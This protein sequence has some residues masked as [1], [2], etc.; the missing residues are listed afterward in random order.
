MPGQGRQLVVSMR[1]GT[2]PSF[3]LF[4]RTELFELPSTMAAAAGTAGEHRRGLDCLSEVLDDK[5]V[6]QVLRE[7]LQF[8]HKASPALGYAG[9]SKFA[10]G[11]LFVKLSTGPTSLFEGGPGLLGKV[12]AKE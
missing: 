1:P 3:L 12:L 10:A 5:H 4:R 7:H 11:A 2:V 8:P 6:A 9:G